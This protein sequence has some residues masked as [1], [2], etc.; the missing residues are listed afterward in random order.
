MPLLLA[1]AAEEV[2]EEVVAVVEVAEQYPA[3]S[4]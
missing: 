2:G 1:V 4:L 3:R